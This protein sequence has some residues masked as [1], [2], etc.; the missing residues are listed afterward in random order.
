L[1]SFKQSWREFIEQFK[2]KV[3]DYN[4]GT[5]LRVDSKDGYTQ[6]NTIFGEYSWSLCEYIVY[7]LP[8]SCASAHAL[9][10]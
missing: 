7:F 9:N 3:E 2:D 5:L 1:F 6:E 4:Y 8:V 10:K